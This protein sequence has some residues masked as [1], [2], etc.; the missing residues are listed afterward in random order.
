M[1]A[2]KLKTRTVRDLAAMAK[3]KRIA[4]WHS[5][6]KDDLV[7][8][9]LKQAKS[10]AAKAAKQGKSTCRRKTGAKSAT[11]KAGRSNP[12][13]KTVLTAYAQRRLRKIKSKSAQSKDLSFKSV[14]DGNGRLKDRLVVMVRDPYWLHAY[15]E[16]TRAS[17]ERARVALGQHWHGARPVLRLSELPGNATTNL[18][19]R[20]VRD[21]P[22]HGGVNNWYIDVQNPPS[23]YQ[24]DV[25]YLA[26]GDVFFSV[27]R[28]NVVSTPHASMGDSFDKNWAEVA[29]D[30]DRIYAMSGGYTAEETNRE[31]KEVFED[32][33]R[34]P[35]GD[36]AS[37]RFGLGAAGMPHDLD[38]EVDT[39][40]IIHGATAPDAHVTLRGE[41]VH[42]RS[43]G[44]FAVRFSLPDR[45]HVLPL[46]ASSGDGVQQRTV[47]LSVDRNT[48]VM[49]PV[50]RDPSA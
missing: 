8:A 44:T 16:L 4:G 49:E 15:W 21:I 6:R 46:V 18:S 42:L 28:S 39:E 41:P 30:F 9:L 32:R 20:V 25:G 37:T 1:T 5:M 45:R 17:I 26:E 35:M 31:L 48:K 23:R 14:G 10:R 7:R 12:S 38:V 2:A 22:I 24:V 29:K 36:P 13:R 47:V 43:D 50:I 19:R 3:K 33:L 11:A 40:L 27:A 34:R